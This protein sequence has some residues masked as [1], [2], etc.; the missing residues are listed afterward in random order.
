M[1]FC[2]FILVGP[3]ATVSS[4][5]AS[6]SLSVHYKLPLPQTLYFDNH[7]NCREEGSLHPFRYRSSSF[8][9][10]ASIS[11][12]SRIHFLSRGLH[13][14]WNSVARL[15]SAV[16]GSACLAHGHGQTISQANQSIRS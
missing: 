4:V 16:G 5:A 3:A 10:Q 9:S 11:R 15:P 2:C 12:P 7:T 1:A 14:K 13:L 8:A 6:P